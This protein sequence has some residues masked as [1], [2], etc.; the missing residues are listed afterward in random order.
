[1]DFVGFRL[2]ATQLV[3]IHGTVTEGQETLWLSRVDVVVGLLARCLAEVEP[4]SKPVDTV[5]NVINVGTFII[6]PTAQLIRC[7]TGEWVYTQ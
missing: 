7:S 1:M 2:T 5:L 6:F 3:E 4:E